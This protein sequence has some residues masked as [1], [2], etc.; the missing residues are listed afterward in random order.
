MISQ[1]DKNVYMSPGSDDD[2]E[3]IN[4]KER[5]RYFEKIRAT[6]EDA[7]KAKEEPASRKSEPV[8]K[9]GQG[10]PAVVNKEFDKILEE[11]VGANKMKNVFLRDD[12]LA[13][14]DILADKAD[15]GEALSKVSLIRKAF[16]E[17]AKDATY[18]DE[19]RRAEAERL[20]RNKEIEIIGNDEI[21]SEIGYILEET[22]EDN[23]GNADG[24]AEAEAQTEKCP[25][26]CISSLDSDNFYDIISGDADSAASFDFSEFNLKL[27]ERIKEINEEERLANHSILMKDAVPESL[28]SKAAGP[29]AEYKSAESSTD[30]DAVS[31]TK[32]STDPKT[33]KIAESTVIEEKPAG[34]SRLP[35]SMDIIADFCN[36]RTRPALLK[37]PALSDIAP[38]AS[39]N[40][41]MGFAVGGVLPSRAVPLFS[42]SHLMSEPI[43]FRAPGPAVSGRP[44]LAIHSSVTTENGALHYIRVTSGSA[45]WYIRKNL[46]PEPEAALAQLASLPD[47]KLSA[48]VLSDVVTEVFR[49]S[50]YVVYRGQIVLLKIVGRTL[51]ICMGNVCTDIIKLD[52]RAAVRKIDVGG[53]HGFMVGDAVF[54]CSCAVECDE[55]CSAIAN[56]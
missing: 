49:R 52:A 27:N 25:A 19:G 47:E 15:G 39:K 50:S 26:R 34:C 56:C 42:R 22:A 5:I 55:W 12:R 40:L 28:G 30:S 24:E 17:R 21:S 45:R 35:S 4:F 53:K 1:V 8:K 46:S 3:A 6:M 16:L 31:I 13:D 23:G 33:A 32:I 11:A 14:E 38:A 48:F 29:E 44:T 36:F 9:P 37:C 51:C 54:H 41:Y 43:V 2:A 10:T 20:C 7:M 18:K